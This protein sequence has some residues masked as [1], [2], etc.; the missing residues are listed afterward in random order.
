MV[1]TATLTFLNKKLARSMVSW[2]GYGEFESLALFDVS[3]FTV[4]RSM[5]DEKVSKKY[6]ILVWSYQKL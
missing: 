6:E 5:E 2:A 3:R 4:P 1:L